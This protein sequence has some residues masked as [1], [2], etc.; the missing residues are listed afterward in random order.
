[1]AS[2][3]NRG[4]KEWLSTQ[5]IRWLG[6]V[7][8]ALS[9]FFLVQRAW[10]FGLYAAFEN[11]HAY[12]V[13]VFHPLAEIFRPLATWLLSQVGYK[14]PVHWHE[15]VIL[16]LAMGA[17]AFRARTPNWQKPFMVRYELD[18]VKLERLRRISEALR[19]GRRPEE[20]DDPELRQRLSRARWALRRAYLFEVYF[21][22]TDVAHIF[23]WPVYWG[24]DVLQYSYNAL[25][26]RSIW[27]APTLSLGLDPTDDQ[28]RVVML[29]IIPPDLFEFFKVGL[30]AVLFLLLNAGLPGS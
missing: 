25:T 5:T 26:S 19:A 14:L 28:P 22:L 23:F 29:G 15:L 30:G 11:I 2:E 21:F 7:S 24:F 10:G 6:I 8:G 18:N 16:Y 9:L 17:A 27:R 4:W 13:A 20:N 3:R 12:Y 1:M